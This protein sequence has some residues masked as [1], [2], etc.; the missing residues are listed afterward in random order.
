LSI[1]CK[2]VQKLARA[3]TR[4][5]EHAA[6]DLWIATNDTKESLP[7]PSPLQSRR[8]KALV[9]IEHQ[10]LGCTLADFLS[11]THTHQDR[12]LQK[13]TLGLL[14]KECKEDP[15]LP[16]GT[17]L[18]IYGIHVEP[19]SLIVT[20]LVKGHTK[21]YI[22]RTGGILGGLAR[23]S[24]AEALEN[25]VAKDNLTNYERGMVSR[26]LFP[27]K[28]KV[29]SE[30]K[31]SPSKGMAA[32]VLTVTREK[33]VS[34]FGQT[35]AHEVTMCNLV[36]DDATL[37]TRYIGSLNTHYDVR[38]VIK[39]RL[40]RNKA[41]WN[42]KRAAKAAA[43]TPDPSQKNTLA[44]GSVPP[45][46]PQK[47]SSPMTT[48]DPSTKTVGKNNTIGYT[49]SRNNSLVQATNQ[50][51]T[52]QIL[53]GG[54]QTSQTKSR[55]KNIRKTRTPP[56]TRPGVRVRVSDVGQEGAEPKEGRPR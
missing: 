27:P 13:R 49:Q 31:R 21:P 11:L 44:K 42:D 40:R 56:S 12:I 25:A 46:A 16:L 26:A 10:A 39:S 4:A 5:T 43:Q 1:P 29:Y 23:F 9:L 41:Y 2:E 38:A 52:Q 45:E 37:S 33:N 50:A 17:E 24:S 6:V 55:R 30:K 3:I 35:L 53:P 54:E 28:E 22:S 34:L 7:A 20:N 48:S 36:H 14:G 18:R 15:V 32:S 8:E 19:T 51:M 47:Q